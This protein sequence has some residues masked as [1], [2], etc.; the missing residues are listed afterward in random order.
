[1]TKPPK[2]LVIHEEAKTYNRIKSKHVIE[3]LYEDFVPWHSLPDFRH[4]ID[5]PDGSKI[6]LVDDP[7]VIVGVGTLKGTNQKM[8]IVAQQ[9]PSNDE[10][11]AKFN[12]GLVKADGY[13]LSYNMME[14]AEDKGLMLNTFIDT[15]GGDPYEYSAEK[16]QSWLISYCQSKMIG[17]K[18]KSVSVVLGLGGSGGAIAIQLAHKRLMLSRAEYSVITAEGCS[19][20]LF[21]SADKVVEALQVLQPTAEYMKKYG[22]IDDIIK[23]PVL[24]RLDYLELTLERLKK[25]IIK[26]SKE[27][28]HFDVKYLKKNL[29]EKID[30]V[31]SMEQD[32]SR[33]RGIAKKLR[34]QYSPTSENPL[35]PM[36]QK[37]RLHSMVLS[38]TSATMKKTV[39]VK[40]SVT[41]AENSLHVKKFIKIFQP[42]LN[43]LNRRLLI[44]MNTLN[45][46]SMMVLS[47]KSGVI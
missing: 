9:T 40:P 15:V 45:S 23:E 46:L 12:Y 27:L 37:C 42:A 30:Q 29:Q 36:Y 24:D 47:G 11:R 28:E 2:A 26:S 32:P 17:L 7:A 41:D 43:A 44:R 21:R 16:L 10:E 1:M 3:Y 5:A 14:Y 20:I 19:A 39:L 33:Y 13:G 18:T 6:E 38:L 8:A 4:K 31:G 35:H 22:I 25:A 34:H